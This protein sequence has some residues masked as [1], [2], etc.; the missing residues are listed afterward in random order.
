MRWCRAE[1]ALSPAPLTGNPCRVQDGGQL[2][3]YPWG[4]TPMDDPVG[5]LP[6]P[7]RHRDVGHLLRRSRRTPTAPCPEGNQGTGLGAPELPL[8][9]L[10]TGHLGQGNAVGEAQR[11]PS[12]PAGVDPER[13]PT[14]AQCIVPAAVEAAHRKANGDASGVTICH[15][16]GPYRAG[17]IGTIRRLMVASQGRPN[18]GAVASARAKETG[19]GPGVGDGDGCL[20]HRGGRGR[21]SCQS[22]IWDDLPPQN[23]VLPR[24]G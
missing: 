9:Y 18:P 7:G 22:S 11:T 12:D 15:G 5:V 6:I 14:P 1:P 19:G 21:R 4:T 2:P 20:R 3:A 13:S 8:G 23:G 16:E 10:H 24:P 17:L